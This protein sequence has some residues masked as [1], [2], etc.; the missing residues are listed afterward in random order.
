MIKYFQAYNYNA[1]Q[2]TMQGVQTADEREE[3][4]LAVET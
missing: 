2:E 4:K 1:K 3:I